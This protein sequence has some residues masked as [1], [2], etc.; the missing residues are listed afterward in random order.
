MFQNKC[1]TQ[2]KKKYMPTDTSQFYPYS[3]FK[4]TAEGSLL[5]MSILNYFQLTLLMY[6]FLCVYRTHLQL[7][8]LFDDA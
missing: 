4:A 5:G 3:H 6:L 8:A 7:N 2:I 1:N